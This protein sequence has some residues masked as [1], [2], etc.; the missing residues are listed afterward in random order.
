MEIKT[1]EYTGKTVI[2]QTKTGN[3]KNVSWAQK[4]KLAQYRNMSDSEF[5]EAMIQKD[6]GISTSKLFELRIKKHIDALKEDYDLSDLKPN[7]WNQIRSLAQCQVDLEDINLQMWNVK[8][9]GGQQWD[10][11]A[12][13]QLSKM[14]NDLVKTISDIQDDLQITRKIRKNDQEISTINYLESLKKKA[15]RFSDAKMKK[16]LCPKCNRWISSLWFLYPSAKK[17][18]IQ[19]QCETELEDGSKC[20]EIIKLSSKD[21]IEMPASN[22]DE[23]LPVSLR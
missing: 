23:L 20:G 8:N 15:K 16:I 1:N 3:T 19:I 18:F 6:L 9:A 11:I 13:T 2:D 17:T 14:R 4:R 7:D 22:N 12:Y 21:L 10:M 5:E